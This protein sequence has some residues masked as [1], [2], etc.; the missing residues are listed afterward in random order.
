VEILLERCPWWI[1]GPLLGLV[2]VGLQWASNLRLG[3]TGTFGEV[4]ELARTRKG[5]VDWR[6]FLFVGVLL[7]SLLFGLL[8]GFGGGVGFALGSF[9]ERFS[10]S[11]AIKGPVLLF[12]GVLIGFGSRM[13]GGCTSGAG[14]C[15]VPRL[16][17]GSI[18]TTAT[19]VLV[20]MAGAQLVVRIFPWP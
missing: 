15:G 10:S 1:G 5:P 9:D 11:L 6:V 4:L 13:A 18:A 17:K 3:M 12:A 20:A 16:S 8:T 7:G 14:L 2:V 19:F